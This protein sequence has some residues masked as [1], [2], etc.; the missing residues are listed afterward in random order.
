MFSITYGPTW[1]KLVTYTILKCIVLLKEIR[2][3]S[4]ECIKDTCDVLKLRMH[5]ESE[6]LLMK[7]I[8]DHTLHS[9]QYF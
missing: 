5:E 1:K 2:A 8:R 4:F 9:L 3:D 7:E 6:Q